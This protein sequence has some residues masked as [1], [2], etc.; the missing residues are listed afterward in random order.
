MMRVLSVVLAVALLSACACCPPR[1]S[2]NTVQSDYLVHVV[3]VWLK[4]PGNQEHRIQ[5]IDASQRLREI[6][7]VLDL[8]VGEVLASDRAVVEDSYDVALS[9]RFSSQADLQAYLE[10]PVHVNAVKQHFVPVMQR[11]Q[12]IDFVSKKP[13]SVH[14]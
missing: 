5:I 9:L 1:S 2:D 11:Y 13:E 10:H 8:H 14:D 7:G 6:P 4:Q 12:V 3:L